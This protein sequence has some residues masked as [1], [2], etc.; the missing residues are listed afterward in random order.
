MHSDTYELLTREVHSARTCHP[1]D[2]YLDRL[3]HSLDHY[4]PD[5]NALVA[6]LERDIEQRTSDIER[7][8]TDYSHINQCREYIRR[9]REWLARCPE[10]SM[11]CAA[12]ERKNAEIFKWFEAQKLEDQRKR[13][14]VKEPEVVQIVQGVLF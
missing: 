8:P 6:S 13:E 14:Q 12:N 10:L 11:K 3:W 1:T 5:I 4:R 9:H 2:I 7:Y